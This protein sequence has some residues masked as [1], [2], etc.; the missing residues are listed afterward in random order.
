MINTP[1]SRR[2]FLGGAGALVAAPYVITSGALGGEGQPPASERITMAG[3]G[4]GGRGSGD[5]RAFMSHPDVQVL[6]V[7]DVYKSRQE[8]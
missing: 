6:A 8:E 7:C 1:L 4:M 3:I 2:R 5:L